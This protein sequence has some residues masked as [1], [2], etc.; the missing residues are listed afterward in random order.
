MHI[1]ANFSGHASEPLAWTDVDGGQWCVAV[2]K[3]AYHIDVRGRLQ[4]ADAPAT[5]V[6]ADEHHGDPGSSSLRFEADFAPFKPMTDVVVVG[7]AHA[8]DARPCLACDVALQVGRVTKMLRVHGP[9][10]WTPGVLGLVPSKPTQ[11]FETMPLRWEL[12]YGGA[13][14]HGCEWHNPVGVGLADGVAEHQAVGTRAPSLEYLHDPV[15][16]WGQRTQPA[17][18]API[19]RSWQPRLSHAG[20]YDAVWKAERF[21]F[22]P[23]DFDFLHFQIAPFDQ[24]FERLAPGTRIIGVNLDP[25]GRFEFEVPLPPPAARFCFRDRIEHRDF[26][27]DTL[28]LEPDL[29]RVSVLWRTRVPVGRKLSALR[30]IEIGEIPAP[31]PRPRKRGKAYFPSLG[32]Y[33]R[34]TKQQPRGGHSR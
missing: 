21:P 4:L 12:A 19:H 25:E 26:D 14:D 8:P 29:Q 3:G 6:Y 1:I 30:G 27:L 33:V 2:V 10:V 7:H 31:S 15:T 18:F 16:R 5:F 32:E 17:N 24:R 23:L 28:I 22:L 9:R 13:N 34:W 11:P 20:T